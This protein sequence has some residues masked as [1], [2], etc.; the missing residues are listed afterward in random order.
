MNRRL[1]STD[2][3]GKWEW[4]RKV[5]QKHDHSPRSRHFRPMYFE[6]LEERQVMS[7]ISPVS[8]TAL[9]VSPCMDDSAEDMVSSVAVYAP[10][11]PEAV[12]MG[13]AV[14]QGGA[15]NLDLMGN[16]DL[17]VPSDFMVNADF[18][19][20]AKTSRNAVT[21]RVSPEILD[22]TWAIAVG[23]NENGEGRNLRISE[24]VSGRISEGVNKD[25][26]D[27]LTP[28]NVSEGEN[29]FNSPNVPTDTFNPDIFGPDFGGVPGFP[30]IPGG[31][32]GGVAGG[33][34][35]VAQLP[36]MIPG[37]DGYG[38][39]YFLTLSGDSIGRIVWLYAQYFND[40]ERVVPK[41]TVLPRAETSTS[42][43]DSG[44]FGTSLASSVYYDEQ[45]DAPTPKRGKRRPDTIPG[46]NGE[47][48]HENQ[49]EHHLDQELQRTFRNLLQRKEFLERKRT[50]ERFPEITPLYPD[51]VAIPRESG[52]GESGTP[53]RDG[54]SVDSGQEPLQ[55]EMLPGGIA[56][57]G[58]PSGGIPPVN[59]R[60]M[61]TP[62][63]PRRDFL[64]EDFPHGRFP[65]I[66]TI[67]EN[68]LE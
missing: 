17:T 2:R 8:V 30:G 6:P 42:N 35:S 16:S 50:P 11:V 58:T 67:E 13:E 32:A 68:S 3:R 43:Y 38:N 65:G 15:V 25:I 10:V 27:G 1:F 34:G 14:S 36:L 62:T 66:G 7:A 60:E 26:N 61:G 63:L 51:G 4:K 33:N 47:E 5:N 39:A 46:E 52:A 20:K 37:F 9:E 31:D 44:L 24:G 57:D 22:A 23:L 45:P 19:G 59:Q 48:N 41:M 54:K 21:H 56:P 28:L 40:Q 29:T 18:V 12:S 64:R 53:Q 49:I 55:S